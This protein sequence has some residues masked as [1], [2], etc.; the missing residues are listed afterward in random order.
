MRGEAENELQGAGGRRR[1][2]WKRSGRGGRRSRRQGCWST[3]PPAAP[4]PRACRPPGFWPPPADCAGGAR[5]AGRASAG[6]AARAGTRC[7]AVRPHCRREPCAGS[8][9]LWPHAGRRAHLWAHQALPAAGGEGGRDGALMLAAP[10]A[11]SVSVVGTGTVG[12]GAGPPAGPKATGVGDPA[13]PAAGVEAG[14]SFWWTA[15]VGWPIR[16]RP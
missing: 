8:R 11:G 1:H 4:V 3:P 7:S 13:A 14:I 6:T 15:S 5:G 9:C 10:E 2:W 12:P 16:G